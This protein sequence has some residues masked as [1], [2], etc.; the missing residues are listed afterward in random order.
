MGEVV[1]DSSMG[2]DNSGSES[3]DSDYKPSE[4]DDESSDADTDDDDEHL[5]MYGLL[6]SG[7][8]LYE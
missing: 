7:D 1:V 2:T 3:D 6:D 5:M 4:G 8:E